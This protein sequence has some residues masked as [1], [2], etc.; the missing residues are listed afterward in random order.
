MRIHSYNQRDV[1]AKA[2]NGN[3]LKFYVQT[4]IILDLSETCERSE[5]TVVRQELRKYYGWM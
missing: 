4:Q 5:I 3:T 2:G 1:I